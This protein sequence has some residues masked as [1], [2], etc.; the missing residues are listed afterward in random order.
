MALF[1]HQ[2][3]LSRGYF[4]THLSYV[5]MGIRAKMA[6]MNANQPS[7]GNQEKTEMCTDFSLSVYL[8]ALSV[9]TQ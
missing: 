7:L 4:F 6:W 3:L 8:A 5:H 1:D 9:S 2:L